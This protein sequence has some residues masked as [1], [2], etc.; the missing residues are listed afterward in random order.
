MKTLLSTICFAAITLLACQSKNEFKS[1]SVDEF[2]TL[3]AQPNVQRLDVRT[4][5]EY[6]N[7]HIPSSLNLDVKA[8]A[9][10]MLAADSILSKE[11]PVAV[12]CRS[13]NRSKTAARIL[14]ENGYEV[15]ELATG[16]LGWYDA[17]KPIEK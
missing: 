2:E 9:H 6:T 10:F 12:Y 7:G 3:I 17:G 16:F 14:T 11:H 5:E 15:V 4:L 8:E 13:G 1:I